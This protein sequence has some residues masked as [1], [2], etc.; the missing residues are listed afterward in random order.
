MRDLSQVDGDVHALIAEAIGE[1]GTLPPT[2][3]AV[4]GVVDRM[5]LVVVVRIADV[6][7]RLPHEHVLYQLA[8][9]LRPVLTACGSGAN[10][11]MCSEIEDVREKAAFCKD[12]L[13]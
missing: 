4:D 9:V 10:F 13:G 7:L 2:L 8:V 5:V 1:R 12:C 11:R 6:A 3:R